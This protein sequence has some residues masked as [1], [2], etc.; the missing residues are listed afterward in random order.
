MNA[1]LYAELGMESHLRKMADALCVA[2]IFL[3]Q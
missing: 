3:A 2:V 1:I